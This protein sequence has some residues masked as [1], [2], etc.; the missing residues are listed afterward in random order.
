MKVCV[1]M[2]VCV[3]VC[4]CVYMCVPEWL[5]GVEVVRCIRVKARCSRVS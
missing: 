1:C 3:K 5:L 2:C 4:L